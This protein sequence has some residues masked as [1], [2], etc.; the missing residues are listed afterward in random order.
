MSATE[1]LLDVLRM[2]QV[3]EDELRKAPRALLEAAVSHFRDWL[4]S[5]AG[6]D[7]A[8]TEAEVPSASVSA[9]SAAASTQGGDAARCAAARLAGWRR[10]PLGEWGNERLAKLLFTRGEPS[11]KKNA[12]A[13]LP[14]TLHP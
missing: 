1:L 10:L 4:R 3:H 12:P 2:A 9:L 5:G 13:P 11:K 8:D 14:H 7:Q 6:A